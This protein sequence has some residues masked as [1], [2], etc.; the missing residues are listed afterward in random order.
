MKCDCGGTIK[1]KAAIEKNDE[2]KMIY[3][4]GIC[5][6]E[7][8]V[9]FYRYTPSTCPGHQWQFESWGFFD[10]PFKHEIF[11]NVLCDRCGARAKK[12]WDSAEVGIRE[13]VQIEDPRVLRHLDLTSQTAKYKLG[14][15]L[16]KE[17]WG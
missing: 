6:E 16:A 14:E 10:S 11:W 13:A 1:F 7:Y 8:E 2:G 4:C 15:D 12:R 17:F 3:Q 9:A 5:R